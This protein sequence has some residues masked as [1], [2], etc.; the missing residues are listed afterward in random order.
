MNSSKLV[1]GVAMIVISARGFVPGASHKWAR[2]LFAAS[3]VYL[4]LLFSAL[5][6]DAL[7]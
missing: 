7:I 6:V 3:L 2:Q 4:P 1:L 5:A